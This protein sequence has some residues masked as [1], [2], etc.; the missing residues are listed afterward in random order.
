MDFSGKL[1]KFWK[2]KKDAE[3]SAFPKRPSTVPGVSLASFWIRAFIGTALSMSIGVG[4]LLYLE[5]Q[6]GLDLQH[7]QFRF[8]VQALGQ[9]LSQTLGMYHEMLQG[10]SSSSDLAN[11]FAAGETG[12]FGAREAAL[13]E[14]LPGAK[15]VRLLDLG[16]N[17][18]DLESDSP[19]NFA[20]LSLLRAAEAASEPPLLEL[21]QARTP[22]A[23]VVGV[24]AVRNQKGDPLGLVQVVFDV[25]PLRQW[26]DEEHLV[27]GRIELQQKVEGNNVTLLVNPGAPKVR[28]EADGVH[29]VTGSQLRLVYWFLPGEFPARELLVAGGVVLGLLIL[30]SGLLMA[31][32]YARM[33]KTL[34]LDQG[35]LVS[36]VDHVIL[37]RSVARLVPRVRDF[38]DTPDLIV[39]RLKGFQESAP[40][41]AQRAQAGNGE[42]TAA[43]SDQSWVPAAAR[44]G[45]TAKWGVLTP[46]AVVFR[47][48]DI[49]GLVGD[50]L[51]GAVA[52]EIGRAI[53][54]QAA[55]QDQQ[56]VI[57]AR[58]TRAS[59]Q[60]LT[61]A[62]INGL[63]ATGRDVIDLGVV[64]TPVLYFATHF[65]GSDSGVM[66]TASSSG[67]EYNG[68]KVVMG[69]EILVGSGLQALRERVENG[70]LMEGDG[71]V[72]QQDLVP[73]YIERISGDVSMARPLKL[74]IDCGHGSASKVAPALYRALGC[75][76]VELSCEPDDNQTG[77]PADPSQ[78]DNLRAL[79]KTVVAEN[80]DLGLAF[81]GDG[82]RLGVVDSDGRIV[83][84]D[85]V[86]MLLS[87]DV[88]SRHPGGDVIF[89]VKCSRALASEILQNGGRPVMWKSGHA[90]MK[91]K[92]RETGALLA[93]EWSGHIMFQERWYGFDD[94][95]Y[96]GARLLEILAVDPRSS[97][98]VVAEYPEYVSTPELF[99]DLPDGEQ[100]DVMDKVRRHTDLLKGAKL[101]T[102]DG[103]RAE[104]EDG[105]GLIQASNTVSALCFRFEAD[106][107]QA[108][109]RIQS[110][111]RA[112]L[113]KV[114][115]ALQPPF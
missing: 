3:P 89:D 10:L 29:A 30:L 106:S 98:E 77:H 38:R 72:S 112:L 25:A 86:L 114:D 55:E 62:L 76:L 64:P 90:P 80:A 42:T 34:E 20:S 101:T 65:L 70:D 107:K 61:E 92:L 26:L 23:H 5:Q 27:P 73:D 31:W 94:A 39:Q 49:R 81:D 100:Y 12:G 108:L 103:L 82:D 24:T 59:G 96:A 37:G 45:Y 40:A 46:L 78:P 111:Y 99:L 69:G 14:L 104:F 48:Y 50:T 52:A 15:R 54:S 63:Q 105:W 84:P 18:A 2:P 41:L 44:G 6:R 75:D 60:Q 71:S 43:G 74:V 56:S 58:D 115:P 21:L 19:L 91:A 53:G 22:K 7:R 4:I 36:L 33:R 16:Y 1:T 51:T 35:L 102:I 88:L 95:L 57:V 17:T 28:G 93:G 83:W 9:R 8:Q 47:D 79:C 110:L 66:V 97:A 113:E 11:L 13:A 68:F 32:S 85:R 67:P 87:A 109:E